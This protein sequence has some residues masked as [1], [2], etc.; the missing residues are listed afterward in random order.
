MSLCKVFV[1]DEYSSVN[2]KNWVL[3]THNAA[4]L[5]GRHLTEPRYTMVK[6]KDLGILTITAIHKGTT[7]IQGE[8]WELSDATLNHLK[9]VKGVPRRTATISIPTVWGLV[10]MFILSPEFMIRF[11]GITDRLEILPEGEFI[12]NPKPAVA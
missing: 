8:V 10:P 6:F 9:Y 2:S 1:Y 12:E 4:R 5:L 11:K 3:K 7:A